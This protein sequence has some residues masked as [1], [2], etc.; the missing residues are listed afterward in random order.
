M[1]ERK[2]EYHP[3]AT[4]TYTAMVS[5]TCLVA[6]IWPSWLI[7]YV[8]GLF[9]LGFGLRPV[10]GWSGLLDRYSDMEASLEE[11]VHRKHVDKRRLQIE[12]KERDKKYKH[13]H[14]RDL[15]LPPNW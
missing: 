15:R 12:R 11:R 14:H 7:P 8:G 6:I 5:L 13:S 4:G 2:F 1:P 3:I 9:F 10:L